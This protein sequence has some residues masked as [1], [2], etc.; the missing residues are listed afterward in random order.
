L[1]WISPDNSLTYLGPHEFT[2]KTVAEW[3]SPETGNRYP[4]GVEI[5]AAHPVSGETRTFVLTPKLDHQEFI[6]QQSDIT[7]WEGACRVTGS[8]ATEVGQAYLEL[9]GYGSSLA[10]KI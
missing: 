9:T 8:D 2:W 7:Y 4:T 3:E 5:K 10:G 1:I 6:S